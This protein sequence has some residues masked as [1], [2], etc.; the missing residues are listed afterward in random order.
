MTWEEL[1]AE[2]RALGGIAENVRL[3]EGRLGRG[4]F[5]IDPSEPA[6]LHC[7]PNMFVPVEELEVREGELRAKPGSVGERE[8]AFFD[9]YQRHFGWSAGFAEQEWRDQEA[10]HNLPDSIK[11]Y[12]TNMGGSQ[13]PEVRF[14]APSEDVCL[15]HYVK[16]RDFIHNG[17]TQ[18]VPI[19]DLVNHLG[20]VSGYDVEDGLGVHGT[21][22]DEVLVRY[23]LFDTWAHALT[24]GFTDVCYFAYSLGITVELFGT[25]S[26]SIFRD[27]NEVDVVNDLRFPKVTMS[28]NRINVPHLTLGNAAAV[29][30]PRAIFRKLTSSICT[31]NQADDA[32]DSIRHF[33]NS[34]FIGL[35]RALR[36]VDGRIARLLSE[37]AI[38]QLDT[39]SACVGARAL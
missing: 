34:K 21:F 38:N 16:A 35:L 13:N 31:T 1:L 32:F 25:H 29:D 10:W 28:G 14:L 15:L 18:L 5:V 19:V 30:T 22:K 12:V 23:N 24:Y 17:K 26:V 39:L 36:D 11:E 27:A 3:G 37:A 20:T 4:V 6:R 2:F 7:T 9:D 33:N 8:R